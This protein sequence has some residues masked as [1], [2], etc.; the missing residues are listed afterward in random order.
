MKLAHRIECLE[1]NEKEHDQDD[2]SQRRLQEH[3]QKFKKR[4][5]AEKLQDEW[6]PKSQLSHVVKRREE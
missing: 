2:W 1:Q 4:E 5:D 3:R 6:I